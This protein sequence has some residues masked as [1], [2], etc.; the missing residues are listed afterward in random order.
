M[1]ITPK[2]KKS[3]PSWPRTFLGSLLGDS[4]CF[5]QEIFH[6]FSK[7]SKS[8]H[9]RQIQDIF[10]VP[11]D[12][13]IRST[14]F[15]T[16]SRPYRQIPSKSSAQKSLLTL[17][18]GSWPDFPNLCHFVDW[19]RSD[20]Q[21]VCKNPPKLSK[22]SLF[23]PFLTL[24]LKKLLIGDLPETLLAPKTP[25]SGLKWHFRGTPLG[26][27]FPM[28]LPSDHGSDPWS[29]PWSD[30]WSDPWSKPSWYPRLWLNFDFTNLLTG[31]FGFCRTKRPSLFWTANQ[32]AKL[33]KKHN[34]D[35]KK[36]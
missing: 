12:T 1:Q 28:T 14:S 2:S 26:T 31:V 21:K 6:D 18:D 29:D 25:F 11:D 30:L 24:A 10:R 22:M 5:A 20:L 33:A 9:F 35:L 13:L 27:P 32:N 34:R 4:N 8:A 7:W 23:D 15:A 3:G 16:V 19:I 36:C 17:F